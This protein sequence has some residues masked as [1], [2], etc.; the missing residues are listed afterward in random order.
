MT[1]RDIDETDD[2]EGAETLDEANL[3]DDSEDIVNFDTLDPLLDVTQTEDD[4]DEDEDEAVDAADLDPDSLDEDEIG[5]SELGGALGDYETDI[6]A[7][8]EV[9]QGERSIDRVGRDDV[10][11]LDQVADADLVEGG[12]D[13]FSN[14]ESKRLSDDDLEALGY[15]VRPQGT[16]SAAAEARLDEALE[17]SFPASDPPAVKPGAD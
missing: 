8:G 11:G 4:A 12:E 5:D 9:E 16:P 10:D 6:G 7:A 14:F 3:T 2:Q 13:D 15:V 1:D 17:E